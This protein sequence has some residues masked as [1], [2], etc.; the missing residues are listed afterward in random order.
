[1]GLKRLDGKVSIVTG[2]SRGIGLATAEVFVDEGASVG[3]VARASERFDAVCERLARDHDVLK[4]EVDVRDPG[5]CRAAVDAVADRWGRVD[6]LFNNAGISFVSRI[7][8]LTVDQWYLAFE[9][10]VAGQFWFAREAARAMIPR[11][12]GSIV[13]MASELAF[14]G[15]IGHAAQSGTKGASLAAT[16]SIAA[17]LAPFGI[18]VNAVCPGRIDTDNLINEYAMTS[19]P[20]AK[21]SAD[22]RAVLMRR[23]GRPEE[24]AHAVLFLA[25]DESS[26]TTGAALA[27][28]GGTINTEP[29]GPHDRLSGWLEPL[30][31]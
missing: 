22:E 25:S 17:D 28:D 27:V 11:R 29:V 31:P 8:V 7:D 3:L 23:F 26:Y 5:Q 19:D 2:A 20:V 30:A 24:V 13:N 6:V 16:R 10:N 9:T 18:R 21:R 4:L 1:M 15:Q 14:Q 12:S